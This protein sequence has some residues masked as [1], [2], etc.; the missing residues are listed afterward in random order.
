MADARILTGREQYFPAKSA[1]AGKAAGNAVP[2]AR[3]G[4]LIAL[5]IAILAAV[6][7]FSLQAEN[8]FIGVL[9]GAAVGLLS[10]FFAKKEQKKNVVVTIIVFALI[11][12]VI[13]YF[14]QP[15][16][17]FAES[18]FSSVKNLITP[19]VE[20]FKQ[21]ISPEYY[22]KLWQ[23]PTTTSQEETRINVEFTNPYFRAGNPL[24]VIAKISVYTPK[25]D[26]RVRPAKCSLDGTLL[27]I[28]PG[29]EL[30]FKKSGIEQYSSVHCKGTAKKGTINFELE[31]PV[32]IRAI[33]PV[34]ISPAFEQNLGQ[35]S[36]VTD[37][38]FSLVIGAY[39]NQPLTEGTYDFYILLKKTDMNTEL[40]SINSIK[41]TT[42][43][44]NLNFECA[45]FKNTGNEVEISNL[46][47]AELKNYAQ[48]PEGKLYI[49][50]CKLRVSKPVEEEKIFIISEALYNI[51]NTY[52]SSINPIE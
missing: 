1:A 8:L 24:D 21:T 16:V 9:I 26:I 23:T 30:T 19:G 46:D 35:A 38:P 11:G 15:I 4:F 39:G 28:E 37:A 45:G 29:S 40:S 48:T 49:F 42:I 25:S 22:Q 5:G 44:T 33:L 34:T 20:Q 27:I 52:T 7:Y 6:I 17:S 3:K 13:G 51:K 12:G 43:S 50:N 47:S 10:W 14:F 36:S 2:I 32:D 41:L 18:G 31:R